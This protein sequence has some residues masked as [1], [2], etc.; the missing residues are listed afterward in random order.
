VCLYVQDQVVRDA[1]GARTEADNLH[2]FN[3]FSGDLTETKVRVSIILHCIKFAVTLKE[4][5]CCLFC[6]G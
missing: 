1:R 6:F 5:H 3:P 2:D 4:S